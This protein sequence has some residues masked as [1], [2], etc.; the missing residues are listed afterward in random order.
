MEHLRNCYPIPIMN[1]VKKFLLPCVALFRNFSLIV[2]ADQCEL[3][4]F[5]WEN[6]LPACQGPYREDLEVRTRSALPDVSQD[7]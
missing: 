7:G 6:L 5:Y 4:A 3:S 2:N 1:T